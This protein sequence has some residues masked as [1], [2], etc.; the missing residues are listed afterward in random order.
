MP[1]S[2][3]IYPAQ[4]LKPDALNHL[5]EALLQVRAVNDVDVRLLAPNT[6][7]ALLLW[8]RL[9]VGLHCVDEF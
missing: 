6:V 9:E 5:V 1:Q 8:D 2:T 4:H 7:E 3:V